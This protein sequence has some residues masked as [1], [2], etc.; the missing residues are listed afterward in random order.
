VYYRGILTEYPFQAHLYGQD[1]EVIRDCI[2]GLIQA[3][4]EQYG[5]PQNFRDWAYATFGRGIAEH[6]MIPYNEKLWAIDLTEMGYDW[7]SSRIP[8][9]N[10]KDVLDG[11][12]NPPKRK[13]GPNA[14][15]CYPLKGGMKFLPESFLP[16]V[17]NLH[18]NT[19]V[20]QIQLK[21][22][23]LVVGRNS[24]EI[25]Y[26]KIVFSLPLHKIREL[27]D[28]LPYEV[29]NAI[30]RLQFNKVYAVN[31]G[32]ERQS[33]SDKH[34][35][36]FPESKF[37]F[38]RTSFPANLSPCMVPEGKSSITA[39]VSASKHKLVGIEREELIERVI[40]DLEF[41]ELIRR[42]EIVLRDL[43]V[44][45][46]AYVIYDLNHMKNVKTIHEF[47]RKN[48]IYPCGRFGEWEYLNMDQA[49]L[50]GKRVA[51]KLM[52]VKALAYERTR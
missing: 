23:K 49:I 48:S 6:F 36:Y 32:I 8:I 31:L 5:N 42:D 47:L 10:V 24:K 17:K 35:I 34:W 20:K 9:P 12:L 25:K 45:N 30:K 37:I 16:Y 43:R 11:A 38:Q 51:E 33:I 50:S 3:T 22:K 15:F 7:I 28:N 52:Q 41:V 13:Y 4:C 26:D 1:Q 39:E 46:P 18:L 19:E 40:D 44:L 27:I 2:V 29:E 14:T 21:E